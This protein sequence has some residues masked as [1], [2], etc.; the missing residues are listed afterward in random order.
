M[1]LRKAVVWLLITAHVN[2]IVGCYTQH[3]QPQE[4]SAPVQVYDE[5]RSSTQKYKSDPPFYSPPQQ[6]KA[7]QRKN[8]HQIDGPQ[9][10]DKNIYYRVQDT[11]SVFHIDID[12]LKKSIAFQDRTEDSSLST[13]SASTPAA[14]H[15]SISINISNFQVDLQQKTCSFDVSLANTSFDPFFTPIKAVVQHLRPGPPDITLINA[16]GG[17]NGYGAWFDYSKSISHEVML[18]VNETT[19]PRTWKFF[20]PKMKMFSFILRVE[21]QRD[22]EPPNVAVGADVPRVQLGDST[23]II[24]SAVDNYGIELSQLTIDDAVIGINHNAFHYFMPPDTGSYE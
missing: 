15:D 9:F 13:T 5:P 16:D 10:P 7:P 6:K 19:A 4:K 23:Q 11:R 12:P 21:A 1:D 18:S 20:N 17:G 2:L 24:F 22:T 3:K 8:Q 14:A